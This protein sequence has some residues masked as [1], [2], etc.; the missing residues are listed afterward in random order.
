MLKPLG[1]HTQREGLNLGYG[2]SAVSAIAEHARQG[3]HFGEPA[4]IIFAFK[5]NGEG[6]QMTLHP[7]WQPNKGVKPTAATVVAG[8]LHEAPRFRGTR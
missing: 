6:H 4:A 2:F 8:S 1:N 3:W 7:G 5:L